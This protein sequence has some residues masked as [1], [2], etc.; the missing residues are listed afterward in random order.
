MVE[1]LWKIDMK[2][3]IFSKLLGLLLTTLLKNAPPEAFWNASIAS[4]NVEI[5]FKRTG[6][7]SQIE[8][9]KKNSCFDRKRH[10]QITVLILFGAV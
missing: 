10:S 5:W 1:N 4:T 9:K 7:I 3:L 8:K 6:A 2:E